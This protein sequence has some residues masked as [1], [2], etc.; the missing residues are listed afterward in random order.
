M[1]WVFVSCFEKSRL[2]VN[3]KLALAKLG[4]D[5]LSTN[6]SEL[7]LKYIFKIHWKQRAQ[8]I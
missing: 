6:L 3:A 5:N 7:Y 1:Q 2:V 4:V 8:R